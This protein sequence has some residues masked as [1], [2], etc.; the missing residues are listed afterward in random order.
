MLALAQLL[1]AG[2][3]LG[4]MDGSQEVLGGMTGRQAWWT[5]QLTHAH[6]AA[7]LPVHASHL[8]RHLEHSMPSRSWQT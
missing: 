8:S 3:P 4:C 1:Q 6:A 2:L 5:L 7:C